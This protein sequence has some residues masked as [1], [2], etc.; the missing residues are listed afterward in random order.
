MPK[1]DKIKTQKVI[2]KNNYKLID[3]KFQ[4]RN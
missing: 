1:R 4:K 3:E 2:N